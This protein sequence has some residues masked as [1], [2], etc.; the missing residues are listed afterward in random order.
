[1]AVQPNMLP[2]SGAVGVIALA[3][4]VLA[5]RWGGWPGWTLGIVASL[6]AICGLGL[7]GFAMWGRFAGF[8]WG[9]GGF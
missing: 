9:F 3:I 8:P 7:F 1:M 4:A 6:V 2:I 5:I